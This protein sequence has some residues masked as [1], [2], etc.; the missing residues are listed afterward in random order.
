M[1]A[2]AYLCSGA[3]RV[4]IVAAEQGVA[5]LSQVLEHHGM[6]DPMEGG[7][8]WIVRSTSTEPATAIH[9]HVRHYL[10]NT[11]GI[12][13]VA[14]TSTIG[15]SLDGLLG[16]SHWMA[17]ETQ[18]HTTLHRAAAAFRWETVELREVLFD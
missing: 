14:P 2:S 5:G 13:K 8:A 9:L 16:A 15:T 12:N 7:L 6:P 10:C 4:I 17:G 1:L 18:D 3:Q 11:G